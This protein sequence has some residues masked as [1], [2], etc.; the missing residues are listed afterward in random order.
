MSQTENPKGLVIT[1]KKKRERK[2]RP[3]GSSAVFCLWSGP[4]EAQKTHTKK[5]NTRVYFTWSSSRPA[6]PPPAP[7]LE[8][9]KEALLRH[10]ATRCWPS[11]S[12]SAP[13]YNQGPQIPL[14]LA[15]PRRHAFCLVSN[16]R[17]KHV[18]YFAV[19]TPEPLSLGVRHTHRMLR[20]T[21]ISNL[22]TK[23]IK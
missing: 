3:N 16:P 7:P 5:L 2:R 12:D 8:S 18:A 22:H 19:R 6:R 11:E 23:K 15:I 21:F 10:N 17:R 9:W 20:F 4:G 14:R 13:G 1:Q